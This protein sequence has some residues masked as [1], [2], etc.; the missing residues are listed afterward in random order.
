[1]VWSGEDRIITKMSKSRTWVSGTT[2]L[3]KRDAVGRDRR[4]RDVLKAI[5]NTRLVSKAYALNDP[6]F[7]KDILLCFCFSVIPIC[8]EINMFYFKTL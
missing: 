3:M 5:H 6:L 2:R 4:S 8:P 7:K 1:M